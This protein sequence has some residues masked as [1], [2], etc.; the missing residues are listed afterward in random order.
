MLTP[1]SQ[2]KNMERDRYFGIS[3]VHP[4]LQSVSKVYLKQETHLDY[5]GGFWQ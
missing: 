2:F 3:F 1:A 5:K 4:T